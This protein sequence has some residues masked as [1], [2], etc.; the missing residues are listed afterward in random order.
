MQVR[1]QNQNYTV[2][3]SLQPYTLFWE[4]LIFAILGHLPIPGE[5]CFPDLTLQGQG[6]S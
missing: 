1:S 2:G 6:S 5:Q 3:A 4:K